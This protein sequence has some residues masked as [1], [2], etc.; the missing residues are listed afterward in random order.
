[1]PTF[2]GVWVWVGNCELVIP[3]KVSIVVDTDSLV[4]PY[5]VF[6]LPDDI[7]LRIMFTIGALNDLQRHFKLIDTHGLPCISNTV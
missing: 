1:M 2:N 7:V 4:F 6:E 5:I 3:L